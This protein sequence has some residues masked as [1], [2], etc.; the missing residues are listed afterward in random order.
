VDNENDKISQTKTSKYLIVVAWG[1]LSIHLLASTGVVYNFNSPDALDL[2]LRYYL[3]LS[4]AEHPISMPVGIAGLLVGS[5]ILA[6]VACVLGWVAQKRSKNGK[7][8][9]ITSAI[10]V[11]I[12]SSL[13]F[14]KQ[15]NVF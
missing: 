1:L 2:R 11:L 12:L 13:I 14:I 8:V 4:I 15:I 3:D 9:I 5:N 7:V 10:C 6:L